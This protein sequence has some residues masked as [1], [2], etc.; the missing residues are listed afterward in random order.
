MNFKN[1]YIIINLKFRPRQNC[2][3]SGGLF[4]VRLDANVQLIHSLFYIL[5]DQNVP[6]Q[7]AIEI[8]YKII[9]ERLERK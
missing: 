6:Y 5:L 9:C 2:N 8:N 4:S 7:L 3:I 1:P